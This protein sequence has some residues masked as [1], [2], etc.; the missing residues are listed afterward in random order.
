MEEKSRHTWGWTDWFVISL[1]FIGFILSLVNIYGFPS[2]SQRGF[3]VTFALL[4]YAIPQLFYLPR[5][6]RKRIF[7]LL[8]LLFGIS[9]TLFITS[10]L[11]SE[12]NAASYFYMPAFVISYLSTKK[13][14]YWA[15]TLCCIVFPVVLT[16]VGSHDLQYLGNQ[17]ANLSLFS[18]FGFSL[19]VFLRQKNQLS[20][21]LRVIEE[22][23][24]ELEHYIDEVERVTL[25]EERNR[26]SRELHDTV[27]HS[28]TASIVAM[29]A[30]QTLMDR[31]P[32]GAKKRLG[33]LIHYNRINLNKIRQTVH[34]MAMN[35][36]TLPLDELL[37]KTAEDF[38]EKTGIKLA[39]DSNITNLHLPDAIKLA[40]LRC[41]QETLTNAKKHGNASEIR[42]VLKVENEHVI[43]K[44]NDNGTGTDSIQ[45]GYGI[46]GMKG[47]IESFRG[48][49]SITSKI[50]EGTVVSCEIPMG[51]A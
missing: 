50:G 44:V 6:F 17:F 47:R 22:K 41:L 25:L 31:N 26:M 16:V 36:L 37:R 33:E 2:D 32:N 13:I 28:L 19:G 3:V 40:F 48:K 46:Q 42:M 15:A 12:I 43:L 49:F 11:P 30:I 18:A 38:A 29:E 21:V 20:E 27:G 7:I 51:G 39:I 34:D 9:Y 35:E 10:F 8:E 1:R 24:K 4:A 14:F 23:N 5:Y 45:D